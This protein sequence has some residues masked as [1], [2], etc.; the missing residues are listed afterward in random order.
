MTIL[1]VNQCKVY[2]EEYQRLNG[3]YLR[4]LLTKVVVRVNRAFCSE[5]L[6]DFLDI[7]P[8]LKCHDWVFEN[9]SNDSVNLFFGPKKQ[10]SGKLLFEVIFLFFKQSD[11]VIELASSIKYGS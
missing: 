10:F 3:L 2:S 4:L 6:K 1:I 8:I 5:R 7:G 9:F 11:G